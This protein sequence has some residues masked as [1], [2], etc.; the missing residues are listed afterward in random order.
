MHSIAAS[1]LELRLQFG[2]SV[3]VPE[4]GDEALDRGSARRV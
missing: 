3:V 2:A 4:I 1:S